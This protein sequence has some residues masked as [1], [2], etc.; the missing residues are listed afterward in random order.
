MVYKR[1]LEAIEY[2]IISGELK[3]KERLIET[4]LS[5]KYKASRTPIREVLRKLEAEGLLKK[6]YNKGFTINDLSEKEINEIY[7]VRILVEKGA[8]KMIKNIPATQIDKLKKINENFLRVGR[9][10]RR[11]VIQLIKLNNHFH[12][13]IYRLSKN[14]I[15]ENL[16]SD[17]RKRCFLAR[18]RVLTIPSRVE[19]SYKEHLEMIKALEIN[20]KK[21]LIN[22]LEKHLNSGK[23]FYLL[24]V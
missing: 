14:T 5:M 6:T 24:N 23:V 12:N 18:F 19:V 22:V 1:L 10:N 13:S 4:E 11:N 7:Q 15:I 20:D 17:L 21:K 3:P 16:I 2:A 8:M 9:S